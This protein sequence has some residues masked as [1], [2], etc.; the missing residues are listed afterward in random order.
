MELL[1]FSSSE[2]CF[3][4]QKILESIQGGS[5]LPFRHISFPATPDESHSDVPSYYHPPKPL[6]AFAVCNG[7]RNIHSIVHQLK[8]A[9]RKKTRVD[10]KV[11]YP[12]T[13]SR[14][15]FPFDYIEIMACPGGC[16]NGGGQIKDSLVRTTSIYTSLEAAEI[17]KHNPAK[18]IDD[19]LEMNSG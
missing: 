19:I 11:C 10:K 15:S 1:L 2:D 8:L 3:L 5:R 17:L 14:S 7:F 4:A 18:S 16:L 9:Y 12:Y 13:C 6:L